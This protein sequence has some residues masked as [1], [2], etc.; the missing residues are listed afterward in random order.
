MSSKYNQD[1][2]YAN[3]I[4]LMSLSIYSYKPSITRM[5][6]ESSGQLVP[7]N[8]SN[9]VTHSSQMHLQK[10]QEQTQPCVKH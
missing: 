10:A 5:K 1:K 6:G 9:S 2:I 3:M 7:V 4:Y 8:L